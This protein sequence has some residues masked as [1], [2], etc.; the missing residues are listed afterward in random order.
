[1]QE[2]LVSFMHPRFQRLAAAETR[3]VGY[4]S[5]AQMGSVG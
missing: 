4:L 5:L 3:S 2:L 1:M